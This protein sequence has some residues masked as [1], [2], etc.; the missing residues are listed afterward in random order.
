MEKDDQKFKQDVANTDI[1]TRIVY[2]NMLVSILLK[3]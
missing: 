2:N 1:I 3:I